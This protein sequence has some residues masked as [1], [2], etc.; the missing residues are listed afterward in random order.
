MNKDDRIAELESTCNVLLEAL[1][2]IDGR[3]RA[4]MN[5]PITA[6]EAYDSFYQAVVSDALAFWAMNGI[7]LREKT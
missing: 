3:L 1:S 5:H 2:S 6:A 4:C 7:P